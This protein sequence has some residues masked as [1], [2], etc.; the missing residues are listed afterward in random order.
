MHQQKR[1][2]VHFLIVFG[3]HIDGEP[4]LAHGGIDV[5]RHG[6]R[7][8]PGHARFVAGLSVTGALLAKAARVHEQQKRPLIAGQ[9][10]FPLQF[11][12]FGIDLARPCVAVFR[13]VHGTFKVQDDRSA[14]FAEKPL[15][16][17]HRGGVGRTGAAPSVLA[18]AELAFQ[19]H[20]LSHDDFLGVDPFVVGVAFG[21]EYRID[22]LLL[23]R[24]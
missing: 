13:P 7:G 10:D 16:F 15:T 21:L 5:H 23:F 3:A 11:D 18:A 4:E 20:P 19:T 9:K 6:F 2:A 17:G 12:Q 1:I 22:G 24:S 8:R 14:V